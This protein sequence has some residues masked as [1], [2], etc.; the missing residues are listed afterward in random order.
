MS[1]RYGRYKE[2]PDSY[3]QSRSD[4]AGSRNDP[5]AGPGRRVDPDNYEDRGYK[6]GYYRD[7]QDL[8][9]QHTAGRERDP[10][11]GRPGSPVRREG[12]YPETENY[13]V[14]GDRAYAELS[15]PAF[16]RAD[17]TGGP[18]RSHLRCRDIMTVKVKAAA[19]DTPIREIARIMRDDDVGAVPIVSGDGKLAGIVTD[20]D[21]VVSGLTTDKGDTELTAHDCMSKDVY[22]AKLN[23]RV[24][25]ALEEMGDHQVRRIPIVDNKDRLIG[26]V[27]LSD[28]AHASHNDRELSHVLEHISRPS[29]WLRRLTNFL[30]L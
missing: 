18:A 4:G 23:D 13:F 16:E 22:T 21:L 10:N 8:R 29:S 15:G 30:G 3:D 24:V 28:V 2:G 9:P 5:G 11:Y 20:R 26:I 17:Y 19:P 6:T 27:S 12:Y 7:G 1:D 25:D 14:D